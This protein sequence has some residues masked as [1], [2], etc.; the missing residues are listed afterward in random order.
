MKAARF[1]LFGVALL[2]LAVPNG[3][4]Q[5]TAPP[6][7][8]ATVPRFHAAMP[9][10]AQAEAQAHIEQ[11]MA[12]VSSSVTGTPISS[13]QAMQRQAA[14]TLMIYLAADNDLEEFAIGDLNEMELVGSTTAVNVVVEMDRAAGY[15]SSNGDWTDTRRFFVNRDTDFDTINSEV[16]QRVGETNTG[17]P[18]ALVDFALWAM[19]AYPADRY[20]LIIW[21][22]GGAWLGLATDASAA[23]DDLSML[24]LEEA[25]SQISA[26]NNG[27]RLD[28]IG[29]DAC[30]MS[31]IEVY[32][33]VA[34]YGLYGVAAQETIPG[35]GWEYA[36]PLEAL[37]SNPEMDGLALGR[38]FVDSFMHFY[39]EVV[40]YYDVFDL[41]MVDLRQSDTVLESINSFSAAVRANP[42]PVLSSIGDARNNT[43]VFGGFDDPQY[44]DLWSSAD[45]LQFMELLSALSPDRAVAQAAQAV[46]EVGAQMAVYHRANP[47]LEES[48]GIAI[49]FP[50]NR[51]A[52]SQ[53]NLSSRYADATSPDLDGWRTFLDTFFNTATQTVSEGP[54]VRIL[55]AYPDV[56]SIHQPSVI[57]MEIAGRDIVDVTFAAALHRED[58]TSVLV[59]YV[60]LVSRTTTPDGA[61]I[62]D[63][64]DG[65]STRTFSWDT[66]MPVISDGTVETPALLIQHRENPE[67]AVVDGRF[68]PQSGQPIDAQLLYDL[69]SRQVTSVWGIRQ[70]PSGPVP[71]ELAVKPGDGFQ[72]YWLY[73]DDD[74]RLQTR[75][76]DTTLTFGDEPFSYR[77]IPAPTGTYTLSV[78]A[79]NISG[80]TARDV[81]DIQVNN[82]GLDTAQRGFTDI[83]FGLSFRYPAHWIEPR[84]VQTDEGGRL[85]TGDPASGVLL[86]VLPYDG[87]S[88]GLDVAQQVID[89]WNT[90]QD[91]QLVNQQQVTLNG[92]DAYVVDYTYTFNG[93]PR[94]G[95]VLAIYVSQQGIGYGFDVDAPA[96]AVDLASAAFE[97]LVDS[98]AFFDTQASLGSSNWV[99]ASAAGGQVTFSVPVNWVQ[100]QVEDWAIYSPPGDTTTFIAVKASQRQGLSNEQLAQQYLTL[101]QQNPNVSDVEVFASEPYYIGNEAWHLVGFTYQNTASGL[102]TAGA[103]FVTTIGTQEYVFWLEAPDAAFD[104]AFDTI[105]SVIIDSFAFN[106]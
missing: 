71:F 101:L 56:A 70:T 67:S 63:W 74:N 8:S 10:D 102:P 106:G 91:A 14:W 38:A 90:L 15:D 64:A 105:F 53:Y 11:W 78:V 81:L 77:L 83:E 57:Q 75:P 25:L 18:T 100:T 4:I 39:T 35:F 22:H 37:A 55:G 6:T 103:Y 86:T 31:Q 88:S 9:A 33:A 94:V 43:L 42:G 41:G 65:V 28:L 44:F 23:E 32:Q 52:Y 7:P 46:L 72:P 16:V 84:F 95:A 36:T 85:F 1:V 59:D 13:S 73:L 60:R 93:Q 24:E 20:A 48:R 19:R 69:A 80:A 76:A 5:G 92:N 54:Q 96:S 99:T 104:Q 82:E 29:F 12:G 45:L 40:T 26:A 89:S 2:A 98:L 97:L 21:D 66:E 58:G 50:R 30:L 62:T 87:V 27:A 79:E 47:V 17:D 51:S 3:P 49:Y 34:P 68:I 61:E